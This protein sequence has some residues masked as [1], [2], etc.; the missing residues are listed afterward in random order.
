MR[1]KLL[2]LLSV[3]LIAVFEMG[4]DEKPAARS[5]QSTGSNAGAA[6]AH[7]DG[8]SAEGMDVKA[9]ML[10]HEG[11]MAIEKGDVATAKAKLVELDKIKAQI[12]PG[13]L[14]TIEEL[15][16]KVEVPATAPTTA[17]A[18]P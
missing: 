2:G 1:S 11:T 8:A 17:P 10:I 9:I 12:S 13:M 6:Q 18:T 16:S 15:R 7:T 3:S 4:C 5:P 14:T